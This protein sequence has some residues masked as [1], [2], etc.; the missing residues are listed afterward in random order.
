MAKM[1]TEQ[2]AIIRFGPAL[3]ALFLC[4][5]IAGSAVGYVWEKSQVHQLGNQIT[6]RESRLAQV[7]QEN[8]VLL[9]QLAKL[10]SPVRLEQLAPSLGL[11]P[12]QPQQIVR[13]PEAP[14]ILADQQMNLRQLAGRPSGATPR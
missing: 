3:K 5:L 9:D 12:A 13:L 2:A 14:V 7:R 1:Q 6:A 8:Q 10:T 11:G 4:L